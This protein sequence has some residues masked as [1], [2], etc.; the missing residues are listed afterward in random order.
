MTRIGL[1]GDF[2][3]NFGAHRQFRSSPGNFDQVGSI[4]IRF[5]QAG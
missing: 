5:D 1:L 4:P 3:G 2:A